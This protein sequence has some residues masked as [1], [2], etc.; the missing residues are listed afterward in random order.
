MAGALTESNRQVALQ[1]WC[2]RPHVQLCLHGTAETVAFHRSHR[3]PR[4]W[5]GSKTMA[6][7]FEFRSCACQGPS[8]S[9]QANNSCAPC[10]N[11][12][13]KHWG[14]WIWGM[15]Q[16]LRP[17]WMAL[18]SVAPCST[19]GSQVRH[20]CCAWTRARAC[21]VE[22]ARNMVAWIL[23]TLQGSKQG[24]LPRIALCLCAR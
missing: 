14:R 24:L 19:S 6:P 17:A 8:L 4:T 22:S 11:A 15:S 13:Q 16:A 7:A 5:T 9:Q 23:C 20:L 3:R 12:Q 10:C 2:R 1:V 21:H 18:L